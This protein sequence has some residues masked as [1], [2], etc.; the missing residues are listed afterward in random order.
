MRTTNASGHDRM[1]HVVGVRAEFGV[2]GVCGSS[3]LATS[4]D[5]PHPMRTGNVHVDKRTIRVIGVPIG[6]LHWRFSP[7][8]TRSWPWTAWRNR[9]PGSA[10]PGSSV[11]WRFAS[12]VLFLS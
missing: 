10:E 6:V 2:V 8:V 11:L 12:L 3:S 9:A 4:L 1:G 5:A 7:R